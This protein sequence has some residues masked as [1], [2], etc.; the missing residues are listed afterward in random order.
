MCQ[1]LKTLFKFTKQSHYGVADEMRLPLHQMP[2]PAVRYTKGKGI[3]NSMNKI[4]NHENRFPGGR[5]DG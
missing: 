1:V 5:R 4:K 3:I 2:F